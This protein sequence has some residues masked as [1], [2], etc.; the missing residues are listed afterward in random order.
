M[1]QYQFWFVVGSQFLYGPEVL[2]TVAARA[3]EMAEK[4]SAVLPY[5]LVYKVTAKTNQEI[6]QVCKEANYDDS[7]A[8]V[9]TWCHTFSP[10]KMWING[11]ADL[12]KPWCHFATQYNREIPN[13]E[14]DM[15]FM[16]L[17]Q[18]AH[19]DR[20]HGFIGARL[21]KPRKVIAGFWQDEE[22]QARIGSWMKAAVG[23]AVSKSMKVM[24]F[25]DNMREVAVTEGDKVEVQAK[26]GW[27]VNTWAVGDLV[28]VMN[29]V[30]EAEV[31]ALMETYKASYDFA[32]D[33]LETIRYQA[34][35]E[36]AMKKMLDAE[37]CLA[38]SNTFQDLWGMRQLP[39]LASQHL[40]AQG[41]G[42]GGE[43]DW[44]VSAMTAILKAM[45]QGGNGA[46]AFMEDYTYHLVKGQEYSLG[47]HM[48][49]VCPSVAAERPRIEVHPLGIG[50]REDPARLV[51]EGKPGDAIVVS[52]IDMGGRLRLICQDIH[53]VKPI[54][55]MPNL[56][57]ARVMWQAEP[58][59]TTGVECWITAGGAHHTVLSY[60]VTAE[61]MKDW[62][63]MMEIEFVHITKDTTVESLEH[64]LFLADLAWKWK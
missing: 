48:L 7:C 15:D 42:Y 6:A 25:G 27:Q 20:E 58:S 28:K 21:R 62:A 60:D 37:G 12:Q 24:R 32:T 34:R 63:N 17:N 33:D 44:K 35:E 45:G 38:F 23:V 2:D 52:L 19:G 53:C 22:V 49:E 13:K 30:T 36:I 50:D 11:L 39:G 40:M 4:L 64:D 51:F 3:A 14:I 61:Q 31:A 26:L 16:N 9:I 18:A 29:E 10:S 54:L 1:K 56:P 8:G 59:L 43:G 47:A 57:V 41:Y 5:P 55:P 46:S